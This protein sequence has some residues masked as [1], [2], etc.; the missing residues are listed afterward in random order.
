MGQEIV[1]GQLDNWFN[2]H[3]GLLVH[4]VV[5]VLVMV[6]LGHHTDDRRYTDGIQIHRLPRLPPLKHPTPQ[7][8]ILP[9][10]RTYPPFRP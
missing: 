7:F 4:V 9:P 2:W 10:L 1:P 8:R 3:G 5:I 6:R